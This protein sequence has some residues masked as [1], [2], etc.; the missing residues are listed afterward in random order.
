MSQEQTYQLENIQE[1]VDEV[2]ASQT[3]DDPSKGVAGWAK[4]LDLP[5]E[6]DQDGMARVSEDAIDALKWKME[7]LTDQV[8]LTL[9][10]TLTLTLIGGID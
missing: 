3:D 5:V 4:E 2:M 7:E 10:L 9:T 8:I 1:W 6:K